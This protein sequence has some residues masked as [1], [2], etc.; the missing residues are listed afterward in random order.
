MTD[1]IGFIGLG[2]M[3][4]PMA[5]N[6]K[7]AGNELFVHARRAESMEP[8]TK[9]GAIACTSPAEV[10]R[11]ADVIFTMVSDTPDV[12]QVILGRDGV[13][14]GL[15]PG[16][17]VIDMSTISPSATRSMAVKLRALGVEMLDAPV[18]GGDVGAIKGTLSIMVG[19][20]EA[21]FKRVKRLFDIMGA[22]VVHIGGNGAGQVCKSCNQVVIGNTIAGVGEAMLLARASGV[23]P[24]KVRTALLGGF[25]NS[26]ALELHGQRMIDHNFEPGFKTRLHQK[27]MRIV[28]EEAHELGV[29]LPGAALVSQYLN[30]LMGR[31]LGELDSAAIYRVQEET[32]GRRE[33]AE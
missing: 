16:S 33:E 29:S 15:R 24:A 13:I 32:S 12:E 5:L 14:E 25:A 31:G 3:G 19:G 10:A 8:L 26:K 4:R 30:A 18:S 28:M 22:N 17:A 23:D 21:T 27:D 9:G 2:I 1:K 6:L 20:D 11:Q 7:N